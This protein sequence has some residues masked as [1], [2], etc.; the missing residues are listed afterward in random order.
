MLN[1]G[2]SVVFLYILVGKYLFIM[3]IICPVTIG[4]DQDEQFQELKKKYRDF[5]LSDKE[6][7]MI[8]QVYREEY[9]LDIDWYPSSLEDYSSFTDYIKSSFSSQAKPSVTK[10]SLNE[11]YRTITTLYTPS[12]LNNRLDRI[13][14]IFGD[15]VS[16]L[17]K[18]SSF[19]VT[20]QQVIRNQASGGKNGFDVILSKVFN[21]YIKNLSTLD[22]QV[23]WFKKM[24]PA[25]SDSSIDANK[26]WLEHRAEEFKKMYENR[27]SLALLAALKI[28]AREG[29]SINVDGFEYNLSDIE[30]LETIDDTVDDEDDGVD[31]G[32]AMNGDRY[33]DYR[34]FPLSSTLSTEA[35]QLL[36]TVWQ[37]DKDGNIIR[38]DLGYPV[39]VNTKQAIV[40]LHKALQFTTPETLISDLQ[41]ASVR[42]HWMKNLA[43]RLVS[44]PD[45]Q[46]LVYCNFKKARAAY[47]YANKDKNGRLTPHPINNVAD[48]SGLSREAGINIS[49]GISLN[50]RYGFVDDAGQLKSEE[51]LSSVKSAI[52]RLSEYGKKN[53]KLKAE[54]TDGKSRSYTTD[55]AANDWKES[56]EQKPASEFSELTDVL[57][58]LGFVFTPEDVKYA[59]ANSAPISSILGTKDG[60]TSKVSSYERL[61]NSISEIYDRTKFLLKEGNDLTGTHLYNYTQDEYKRIADILSAIQSNEVEDRSISGSKSLSAAVNPN[62]LH[63]LVDKLSNAAGLSDAEYR[64]MLMDDFGQYEGMSLGFGNDLELTGWL[65]DLYN[66]GNDG[67]DASYKMTRKS[68]QVI[69]FTDQTINR[70]KD[71]AQLTTAEHLINSYVMYTRGTDSRTS[72]LSGRMYEVPIQS[73]YDTAYNFI[74]APRYEYNELVE[75][76]AKEVQCE[77]QRIAAIQ[78][79]KAN[80]PSGEPI[81]AIAKVYEDRGVKFQIFPDLNTNGFID[82]YAAASVSDAFQV[83]KDEVDAQLRAMLDAQR[84][85]LQD[86]GMFTPANLKLMG[87]RNSS[88][89]SINDWILNSFYARQQ[90]TKLMFGGLEHFKSTS[91]FE[92]RNMYS[93]AQRLPMYTKATYRG[94]QVGKENQR[95]IY[96]SDDEVQSAFIDQISNIADKL[97]E[98]GKLSAGQCDRLKDA[99]K[100]ITTTDGQGLRT[101]DSMRDVKIMSSTWTDADELAYQHIKSKKYSPEDVQHFMVGIKPVYTGYETIPAQNGQYQKPVRVPVLHKYSEMVLLP[102]MLEGLDAQT[103]TAPFR[104][105]NKLNKDL[106]EG[107]EIDL[108]LFGSG[109]KVGAN[110]VL[111]VFAKD[112]DGNRI[113]TDASS[114]SN[115]LE[116][117][118]NNNGFWVHN[119]PY[120]YYG[121]TSS[122]HADVVDTKIAW[123]TQAE[124]EAWGNIQTED[125]KG[126]P[127]TEKITVA[128]KEMDAVKARELFYK[129][130]AARTTD[131]FTRISKKLS[132]KTEIAK[133]LKEELA[134]KPYQSRELLFALQM[135]DNGKFSYPLY[136]PN[137]QHDVTALMSSI[138]KKAF[139]KVPTKGANMT[140][141]TSFGLDYEV[142]GMSFDESVKNAGFEPL[143]IKFDDNG[144]FKYV[145]A[146]LPIYDSRLE[147][148]ADENGNITPKRL[149]QLIKDGFIPESIL[150]FI[151]YRTPSDA[152]HSV[153]PCKVKGFISNVAGP[154][155]RLPRE[156]MKMTGH[157]YDGDKMRCHFKEFYVGWNTKAIK[158]DFDKFSNTE[159]VLAILNA[160]ED[161]TLT[162]YEVF[163][164]NATSELNPDSAKYRGIKEVAYKYDK[165]PSENIGKNG[166]YD[167]LNNAMID[168]MFGQLTSENGG[169][170]MFIP[171]GAEE[172]K[173]Y[174]NTIGSRL[175]AT[176]ES[177]FT[178]THA[179]ESHDYMMEG[180]DM[181]GV[182][183][184][185]NS[186]ASMMQRINLR[187]M[188][189]NDSE[190]NPVP[191]MFFGKKIDKLFPVISNST[192][193]TLGE[194]RLLN[195]AVDNGKEPLLGYLNQTSGL[196]HLTNFLLSAGIDEEDV[197]L[198][199]NQPVMKEVASVI[200]ANGSSFSDAASRVSRQIMQVLPKEKDNGIAFWSNGVKKMASMTK[201]SLDKNLNKPF[202]TVLIGSPADIKDQLYVLQ[203]MQYINSAAS[204]LEEFTKLT[205]PE[206]NSGGIDS[207]LG[208]IISK[209]IQLDNFRERLDKN[210]VNQVHISGMEEVLKLRDIYENTMTQKII[211]E[212]FGND[213][214]EVVALNT[215]MKDS[216]LKMFKQYF[217]QA[218]ESWLRVE[219]RIADQYSYQRL[220]ANVIERIGTDM[221]LWKLLDNKDFVSG[222]PQDEQSRII[223][224]VPTQLRSL[225]ERIENAKKN[226]GKDKAADLLKDNIFI[227]NLELGATIGIDGEKLTRIR[228]KLNGASLEDTADVIRADWGAMLYTGDAEIEQLAKDLF[229]YNQYTNGFSYGRYEF[230]HFAPASIVFSAPGYIKALNSVLD[231]DWSDDEEENFFHQYMMN[232]WDDKNLIDRFTPDKL[233][234][235][236]R[237]QIGFTSAVRNPVDPNEFSSKLGDASYI[238]VRTVTNNKTEDKLYRII[239]DITGNV[240]DLEQAQKLGIRN[241]SNQVIVQYNPRIRDFRSVMP[242]FISNDVAWEGN[243]ISD[244]AEMS[245]VDRMAAI[246]DIEFGIPI[247]TPGVAKKLQE[248]T[249]KAAKENGGKLTAEMAAALGFE[250][251]APTA[252]ITGENISSSGSDFA[253]KLTNPGNNLTV[254]YKGT[255]F[256]NAEH[257][258]QTWKSGTFDEVAY[259]SNSFKPI[260]SKPAD[261]NTNYQTMVEILT[262]KLNQHP[263]L[264]S[265]ITE[266]G[267][268][269][270]LLA[271]T[272][273]VVGDKYWESAGQNKFIE[274]LADAYRNVAGV[275]SKM[276]YIINRDEDGNIVSG[277]KKAT[278]GVVEQAR[279]QQ[280]F[281]DLNE[282]LRAIL[283]EKGISVGVLENAEDR[284]IAGGVTDFSAA[285]VLGEGLKELIRISNGI[286]G[287]YALPEEFAHVALEMLGH[288]NP[289]VSRLLNTLNNDRTALQEAFDGQFE[290]YSEAYGGNMEKLVTEAAGKLVAKQLFQHQYAKTNSVRNI[291]RRVC[292]AIKSFFRKFTA[293]QIDDAIMDADKI[294][295]QLARDLLSGRLADEMKLEKITSSDK[296][297]NIDKDISDKQDI[298]HKML[299]DA[300]N[301]KDI[302]SRRLKYSLGKGATSRSLDATKLQISKLEK[303]I[304]DGKKEVAV[305]DY[306]RDTLAF[307]SEMEKSLDNSINNRPANAVCKKLNV[308]KDT[309]YSFASVAEDIRKAIAD[310]ELEKDADL[311]TAVRDVSEAVEDFWTKYNNI[312][313]MYFEQFLSGVYGKDGVTVT[314]GRN[315]GKHITIEDMARRADGDI[316]AAARWLSAVSDCG[317]YVLQAIDDVTRDAKLNARD[318]VRK[319]RPKLEA[320]FAELVKE[321][322]NRDQSWMFERIDGKRTGR[323]VRANDPAVVQSEARRNFYNVFMELKHLAD[324][325]V[326]ESLT[327]ER[328]MIMLRKEHYEKMKQA[329]GAKAK[330]G[331]EWD[332]AKRGILEMGDIDFENEVVLKDLGGNIVDQLP[333]KFLNKG[334]TESYDDMTE[335]A[336]TSLMTYLGMA[337]EYR[338]MNNVIGLLE[339]ARYMSSQRDVKQKRGLRNLIVKAGEEKDFH[340][341]KP[342]TVKQAKTNIQKAMDDFFTMH[343]YGHLEKD[344]GTIGKTRISKRKAVNKLV[345]YTSLTQMAM[346]LHQ[347][348]AN[349]NTGLT[350]IV[351]ESAGGE[352]GIKDITKASAIWMKES[353]D[354]LAET[355]KTDYDNKL[356]LWMDYFD[357]HQDNGKDARTTKYGKSDASRAFNT[358]L[359]YAGL[360]VGEDYLSGTTALAFAQKYK[361][362]YTDES[363]KEHESN[364]WDAYKVEYV[365]KVNKTGAY[366][367]LKPGYTK[368]D[369]TELTKEDERAFQKKVIATNF[370]LQ[371]IYNTDDRSAIQQHS[372]GALAIMYRKWIAPAIKRRYNGVQYSQLKGEYTEG[373]YATAVRT[374]GNII[375]DWF[376][377]VSEEE[378]EKTI[379]RM[380]FDAKAMW[381]AAVLNWD[382]LSDYEK[383]NIKKARNEMLVVLGLIIASGLLGMLPPD[384]HDGNKFLCWADDIVYTQLLR[385]RSEIGSQA[386]TPNMLNEALRIMSSPFAALRP[387]RDSINIVK[388]AWIPNYFQKVESGRYKDKTKA[389]KYFMQSPLVALFRK[390]DSFVDPTDMINFYKNQNY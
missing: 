369:G 95:V 206:S 289:L 254:E 135:R 141:T 273:N 84:K 132:D 326:P 301:R 252:Q 210:S 160:N 118:I 390:F 319:L 35:R 100:N 341:Q 274:A 52:D 209:L 383:G 246:D 29:F 315:K 269:Q 275:S 305:I 76:L 30:E 214:P 90:F 247:P 59:I 232:H 163:Q 267:G 309:L 126:N 112:D 138:V 308:V 299:Q 362:K 1:Y 164:K 260:G 279:A 233:P 249:T 121:I 115:F 359:L 284:I 142:P 239:R 386:P 23:E 374:A 63:E 264:I 65:A 331:E 198:L 339:N 360:T 316:S 257:A 357:I 352:I 43:K 152:E 263:E 226:P 256:R 244:D 181:I 354:R 9:D 140:Q 259:N 322:G 169:L 363:G 303:A 230:A 355:G 191:V 176:S 228:F 31:S 172:T 327:S 82:R 17:V 8:L 202:R 356:S 325:C 334:K 371:G 345:G 348:I 236:L 143:E 317:D 229:K 144:N 335:D 237:E 159:A 271:S 167:A 83:A 111:D 287:E 178:V 146:Y 350:Q 3:S 77:A 162:P 171:G 349:V 14:S 68:F 276:F 225:K 234:I 215:L 110:S 55:N 378:S 184:L 221:I 377:P 66:D 293:K 286:E 242:V 336:A 227:Q 74:V 298:L 72:D 46:T 128:G 297:Y 346:N 21:E 340:Y 53:L 127:V 88:D 122:M 197:H 47:Y 174:A 338:E 49:S 194:S 94:E 218:R 294:S 223:R 364:L 216:I 193:T 78:E 180:A 103:S 321:Q 323:Y 187:Y 165:S 120:K 102:E 379:M 177:P 37:V 248:E 186:A 79:R 217:P 4:L 332:N 251:E 288:D 16:N 245:E 182:Y 385:L 366:L 80:D 136:S 96:I 150:N 5:N 296:F 89:K 114:M 11:L 373:Y 93:H 137:V 91:D 151:A 148:F 185:F 329:Q 13:A 272:H 222:N 99:Y 113:L 314:L 382:K 337:F 36:D 139:T 175:S 154:S 238:I 380:L 353:A 365:D 45:E 87:I 347:R 57:R 253:K 240:V 291:L 104:A 261:R 19:G 158:S 387:M 105:F 149:N 32:E 306:L 207:S 119:L 39:R 262:A 292:D 124:K 40:S 6:L 351:V 134:S 58:G 61:I 280:T 243:S 157:D 205:R 130:K 250:D 54:S 73:D 48:G 107:N 42:Y 302:L 212:E 108:F 129:I 235:I 278:P 10:E 196:A 255:K 320:A 109:V 26:K 283:A 372:L 258:Y 69:D 106:G 266:R 25:A 358:H 86:Y 367:V 75:K 20:R 44:N 50:E 277:Y 342:Y 7:L 33:V 67:S 28:G 190:G 213:L 153:I 310:G 156:I 304:Q 92:K 328:K 168:L 22:G 62:A 192:F 270:Y 211:N 200:K 133:I 203:S 201:F 318:E 15:Y 195:S 2:K 376:A 219:K 70:R 224:N 290:Q 97:Y 38:D 311:K 85:K 98:Q 324:L 368:A 27:D 295:S 173:E 60:V 241:R 389:H 375:K 189:Q 64:Q 204:D 199:F 333:I 41:K 71:F 12:M 116:S 208:G 24:S 312:S 268:V 125:D 313:M 81:R 370:E 101:L 145:E 343:I 281:H 18:S 220:P 51:K 307:M 179:T 344:E 34:T 285:K 231:S 147:Q 188:Q 282:K 265:G 161:P 117:R 361:M 170:K 388:L 300:V 381:N 131:T 123:A 166:N 183:A 384:D 155:I 56:V 330:A